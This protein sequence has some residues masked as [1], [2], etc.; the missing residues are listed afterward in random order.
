MS[1]EAKSVVVGVVILLTLVLG[2]VM[3]PFT[4]IDTTERGVVLRWGEINRV[5][6]PGVHWRTPIAED[7]IKMPVNIQL[8]KVTAGASSLDVQEVS[9]TVAL[10]YRL[11]S[12]EVD[13]I[14][15]SLRQDY[16][17]IVIDQ[18]VQD[19]IKATTAKFSA[20]DLIAKRAEVKETMIDGLTHALA[21]HHITVV[22]VDIT[23]FKFSESFDRAIEEKVTAEQNALKAENDLERI[24]F[25]ADQKVAT[26][27][28]NAEATRLEAQA[29]ASQSGTAVIEK[30]YA[31]A[32]LE[33]AKSWNGVLPVNMYGSAPIPFLDVKNAE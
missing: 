28:A 25:E 18:A 26:A 4:I 24:Q 33:R 5:L 12:T 9:T 6:E 10:Q 21:V 11:V 8:V 22:N 13:T 20:T 1:G 27:E 30:I 17:E 2:V 32:A 7:V 29:L 3:A 16:Q 19:V 15:S 31:E 23:N 14:Y